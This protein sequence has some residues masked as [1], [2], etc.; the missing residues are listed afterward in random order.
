[1]LLAVVSVSYIVIVVKHNKS[2]AIANRNQDHQ[3]NKD[4][5]IKVFLMIGSQLISWVSLMITANYFFGADGNSAPEYVFEVFAL[6]VMPINSLL[7]PIFYSDM[8]KTC[9]QKVSYIINIINERVNPHDQ[10]EE[11]EMNGINPT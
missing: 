3:Q 11:I 5:L 2:S 7:N 10:P 9:K 1:M 4:L 6:F 8:Y